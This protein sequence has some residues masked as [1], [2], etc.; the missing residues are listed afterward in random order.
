MQVTIG[1]TREKSWSAIRRRINKKD[2]E[3][4]SLVSGPFRVRVS[5]RVSVRAR[6]GVGSRRVTYI[7]PPSDGSVSWSQNVCP[8]PTGRS[9]RKVLVKRTRVSLLFWIFLIITFIINRCNCYNVLLNY[10]T[11]INI[12]IRFL[13]CF[14]HRCRPFSSPV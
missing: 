2:P 10:N 14:R 8:T 9:I 7:P 3:R 5:V 13:V 1:A 6:G 4:H 11:S 12:N